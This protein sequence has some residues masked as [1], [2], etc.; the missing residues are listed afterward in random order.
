MPR[1]FVINAVG[2]FYSH[3]PGRIVSWGTL[4][5]ANEYQTQQSAQY[6][7]DKFPGARVVEM[8]GKKICEV[9]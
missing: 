1:F 3:A 6:T 7:A 8:C 9:S 5:K 4:P 2:A